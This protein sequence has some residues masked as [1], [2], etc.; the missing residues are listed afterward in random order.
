[1]TNSN[2]RESVILHAYTGWS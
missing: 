2:T 1:M